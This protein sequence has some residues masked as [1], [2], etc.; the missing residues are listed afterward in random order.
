MKQFLYT[1]SHPQANA[2]L[3]FL[4]RFFLLHNEVGIQIVKNGWNMKQ[5]KGERVWEP[6]TTSGRK[7][8]DGAATFFAV[9]FPALAVAVPYFLNIIFVVTRK[10]T[11]WEKELQIIGIIRWGNPFLSVPQIMG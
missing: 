1:L 6:Q 8:L 5:Y 9:D 4:E 2:L 10:D 3:Y 7:I 11:R